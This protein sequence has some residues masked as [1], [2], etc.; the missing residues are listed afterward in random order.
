MID[1]KKLIIGIGYFRFYELEDYRISDRE[2]IIAA[3]A[4]NLYELDI[5]YNGSSESGIMLYE[6]RAKK[7]TLEM[8]NSYLP[9]SMQLTEKDIIYTMTADK[10]ES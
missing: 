5:A 10:D 2:F 7:L 9:T 6:L 4:D 3:K 8:L 1:R